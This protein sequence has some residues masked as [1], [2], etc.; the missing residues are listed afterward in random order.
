MKKILGIYNCGLSFHALSG[1]R[2]MCINHMSSLLVDHPKG[3]TW[4]NYGSAWQTEHKW[5]YS[6]VDKRKIWHRFKLNN[7]LN[8]VPLTPK[9]NQENRWRRSKQ[10]MKKQ[11]RTMKKSHKLGGY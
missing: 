3:F 11:K 5:A 9:Q 6:R 8:L 10:E 7:Y 4:E 1:G 2:I